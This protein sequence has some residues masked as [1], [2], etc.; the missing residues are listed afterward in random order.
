MTTKILRREER[1]IV[2]S[3]AA[4]LTDYSCAPVGTRIHLVQKVEGNPTDLHS[5]RRSIS[6]RSTPALAGERSSCSRVSRRSKHASSPTAHHINFG[7]GI[8]FH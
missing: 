8:E 7:I 2:A 3:S 6:C 4:D 1:F 5:G